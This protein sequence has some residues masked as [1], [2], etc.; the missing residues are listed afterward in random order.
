[1]PTS[2]A[3]RFDKRSPYEMYGFLQQVESAMLEV[4]KLASTVVEGATSQKARIKWVAEVDVAI[5]AQI[6]RAAPCHRRCPPRSAD[7]RCGGVWE[8]V[9]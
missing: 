3:H 4:S 6:H 8:G 9:V 7:K 2:I 5:M 1:M